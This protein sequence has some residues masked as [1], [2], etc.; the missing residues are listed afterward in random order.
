MARTRGLG[1]FLPL[2]HFLLPLGSQVMTPG[3]TSASLSCSPWQVRQFPW[4]PVPSC[5]F[6]FSI[7][8]SPYPG[9]GPHPSTSGE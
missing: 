1:L 8:A 2:N 3:F 9:S 7:S 4:F 5:V 6:L